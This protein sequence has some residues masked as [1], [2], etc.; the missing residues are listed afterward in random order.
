MDSFVQAVIIVH[1]DVLEVR[2]YFLRDPAD[3]LKRDQVI[4][5]SMNDGCRN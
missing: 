5:C 3:R 1:N 4:R 2:K